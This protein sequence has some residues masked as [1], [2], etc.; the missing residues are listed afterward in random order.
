MKVSSI[1]LPTSNMIEDNK[2]VVITGWGEIGTS[3]GLPRQLQ[4][5]NSKIY[6]HELCEQIFSQ[7]ETQFCTFADMGKGT[8][9][10]DAGGP[11]VI[12]EYQVGLV[13]S[14]T[15]ECAIGI[16]D[17]NTNVFIFIDWINYIMYYN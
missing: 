11:V 1:S 12:G 17:V 3:P 7:I 16:P 9:H 13:S 5:L 15:E 10:G 14:G 2:N 8:C 6:N 4:F